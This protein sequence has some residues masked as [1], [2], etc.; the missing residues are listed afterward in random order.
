[1]KLATRIGCVALV[2]IVLGMTRARPARAE[3][4]V[5]SRHAVVAQEG[6][7]A[8][9]GREI[10]RA[11]GNAVDA[12]IGTAFALAVTL[13]EAGN[14]GG[15]GFLVAYLPDRKEVVTVDFREMAPQSATPT[16][17]L[18]PD[19]KPR[20]RYRTGAW[21]AGVPGTV[22]GLATAHARWGK[23]PWGE[24]ARPAIRLAKEGFPISEDLASG[25]NNQLGHGRRNPEA[26]ASN[27]AGA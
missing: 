25:L 17:Y 16:M 23:R 1:M 24:L 8:E 10:L 12:A 19:G 14:L 9:A 18:G 20:P 4:P 21:A 7:A 13:P 11:G 2:G 5:F 22:R 26:A 3:A 6:N 27:R 15:G